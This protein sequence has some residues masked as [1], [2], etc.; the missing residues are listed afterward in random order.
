MKYLIIFVTGFLIVY[1]FSAI[2][3]I[4]RRKKMHKYETS[5]QILYLKGRYKLDTNKVKMHKFIHVLGILNALI[6]AGTTTIISLF[7]N[8]FIKL[9][10]GFLIV[11]I[12]IFLVYGLIGLWIK[13]KGKMKNV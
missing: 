2:L 7:D 5:V 10:T 6:I 12:L 3:L 4:L 13:K 9:L 8:L 1:L 11:L